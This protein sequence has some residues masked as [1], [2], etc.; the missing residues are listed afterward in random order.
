MIFRKPV[1]RHLIFV[2]DGF[3]C[4]ALG[5][6]NMLEDLI[7]RLG[8]RPGETTPDGRFTLLRIP[9]IGAC[10]RSPAMIIDEDLHG[11][12]DNGKIDEILERYR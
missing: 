5:C 6:D 12:L 10:D 8:I 11:D 7:S 4:W 9:C 3:S 2:C 1:G